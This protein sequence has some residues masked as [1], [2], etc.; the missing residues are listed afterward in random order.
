MHIIMLIYT[1][2]LHLNLDVIGILVHAYGCV[3]VTY[4]IKITY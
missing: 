3:Y 4:F 2:K 1:L